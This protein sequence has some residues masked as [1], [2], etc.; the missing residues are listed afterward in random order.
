MLNL[1]RD[2]EARAHTI[3]TIKAALEGYRQQT[4]IV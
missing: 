3:G 1:V 2:A 4:L